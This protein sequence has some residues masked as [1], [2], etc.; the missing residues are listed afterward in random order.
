MMSELLF[1]SYQ[2]A[3]ATYAVDFLLSFYYNQIEHHEGMAPLTGLIISSSFQTTHM[4]PVL[5]G[6][7]ITS[8]A[9]RMSVG[10]NHAQTLLNQSLLL[11][12]P[13]HRPLLTPEAIEDIHHHHTVTCEDF[14]EQIRS[15]EKEYEKERAK[16]R[17]VEQ[18][19]V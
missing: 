4:V 12:Y 17:R 7:T 1:E 19:R 3:S 11:K 13:K 10:G 14:D 6:S 16:L 9:K 8:E 5:N 18:E 2:V 15:L